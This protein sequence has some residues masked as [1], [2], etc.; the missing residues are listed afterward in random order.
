VRARAVAERRRHELLVELARLGWA[1]DDPAFR[2]VFTSTFMPGGSRELWDAFNQL[3]RTTTSAENAAHVLA[4][5]GG[6]DVVEQARAV[7]APTLVLHATHDQRP[8]FEQGRLM[9]SLVPDSRF[10]ALDSNNH[11]LLADEPAW[12]VFLGEVERFL[13]GLRPAAPETAPR[14]AQAK[15]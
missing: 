6:I 5:T 8:P 15:S 7:R 14:T 3:Q 13:A 2:Q 1:Q 9:A 11:I 10:R 12:P 4:F